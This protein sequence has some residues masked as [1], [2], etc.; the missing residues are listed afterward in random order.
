MSQ[1]L[2]TTLEVEGMTCGSCV[3]HINKAL[4][5]LAGVRTVDVKLREGKVVV[6]HDAGSAPVSLLLESLEEAG[7]EGRASA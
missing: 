1:E 4:G 5:E 2:Q 3:R 6:R 7:Y